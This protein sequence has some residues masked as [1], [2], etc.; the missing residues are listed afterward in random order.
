MSKNTTT[1]SGAGSNTGVL[2]DSQLDYAIG[3]LVY[4]SQSGPYSGMVAIADHFAAL[5]RNG[6]AQRSAGKLIKALARDRGRTGQSVQDFREGTLAQFFKDK[7]TDTGSR[8]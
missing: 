7:K 1:R 5:G 2:S 8:G 3:Q 6:E 4:L